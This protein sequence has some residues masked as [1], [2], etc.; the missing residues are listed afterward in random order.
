MLR[1]EN[2]HRLFL[3]CFL[4]F[5]LGCSGKDPHPELRDPIYLDLRSMVG[6]Y[7]KQVQDTQKQIEALGHDIKSAEP[8][9]R[10][11]ALFR[12]DYRK[13]NVHLKFLTQKLKY[14]QIRE[15]RRKLEDRLHYSQ[16]LSQEREWPDP[17]EHRAYLANKKL[18]NAP[19]NWNQRVPKLKD[20]ITA[21]QPTSPSEES[22]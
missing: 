4:I 22:H 8:N 12:K 3:L 21:S 20:R 11:L 2:I 14:Y 1:F 19:S 6:E 18:R 13:A 15:E 5:G 10:E 17:D 7:K 16:A 9:T